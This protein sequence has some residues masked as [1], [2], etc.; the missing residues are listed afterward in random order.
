MNLDVGLP[1]LHLFKS[2]KGFKWLKLSFCHD[3]ALKKQ[4]KTKKTNKHGFYSLRDYVHQAIIIS[5]RKMI[6]CIIQKGFIIQFLLNKSIY[7]MD[8]QF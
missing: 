3:S 6:S 1:V 8:M 4:N 7:C 5:K 2:K